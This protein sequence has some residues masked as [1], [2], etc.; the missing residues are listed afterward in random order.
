MPC[1]WASGGYLICPGFAPK[2]ASHFC[3]SGKSNQKRVFGPAGGHSYRSVLGFSYGALLRCRAGLPDAVVRHGGSALKRCLNEPRA[4]RGP[5]C[6]R[7][8]RN[9]Y[10]CA[11]RRQYLRPRARARNAS[12]RS[13]GAI[14]DESESLSPLACLLPSPACGRGAGGEGRSL[15][16]VQR[17]TS[18]TCRPS[19]RPSPASG[20]GSTQSAM[21]PTRA[22]R[23]RRRSYHA[24][25]SRGHPTALGSFNNCINPDPPWRT[26]ASGSPAPQR[27]P[28]PYERSRPLR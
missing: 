23:S 1:G 15:N 26:K 13:L 2:G 5:C 11:A 28:A 10:G 12:L 6:G 4:G 25:S 16:E 14:A 17:F 7:Q 20:R 19:P 21:P 9:A 24:A 22:Q 27:S 3:P 8:R 18:W